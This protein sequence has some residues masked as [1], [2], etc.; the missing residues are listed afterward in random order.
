MIHLIT[1]L[2]IGTATPED[3]I[4][5]YKN[6]WWIVSGDPRYVTFALRSSIAGPPVARRVLAHTIAKS[7]EDGL[8]A[9]RYEL[10]INCTARTSRYLS[11]EGYDQDG[12]T[13]G[14]LPVPTLKARPIAR[15]SVGDML[16]QFACETDEHGDPALGFLTMLP[17]RIVADQT[18]RFL[19]LGLS[20]IAA[21]ALAAAD[22]RRAPRSFKDL[23]N[24]FVPAER[25]SY[26]MAIKIPEAER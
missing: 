12:H 17:M 11:M 19:G 3:V 1:A 22:A 2:L 24:V 25:Q 15:N 6:G 5:G 9:K 14:R 16:A 10:I 20:P 23:L 18:F 4:S 7:T 13:V 21:A 26:V 8:L